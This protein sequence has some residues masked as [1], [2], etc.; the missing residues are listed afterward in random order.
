MFTLSTKLMQ[1]SCDRAKHTLIAAAARAFF[2][3]HEP[4]LTELVRETNPVLLKSLNDPLIAF[5]QWC[6]GSATK[7]TGVLTGDFL[8]FMVVVGHPMTVPSDS[9]RC[10]AQD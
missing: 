4:T 9:S 10:F 3:T 6:F 7:R 5:C 8:F 1:E 2:N